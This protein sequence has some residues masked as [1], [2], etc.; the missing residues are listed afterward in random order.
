[1]LNIPSDGICASGNNLSTALPTAVMELLDVSGDVN[2]PNEEDMTTMSARD[3]PLRLSHES[4]HLTSNW[5]QASIHSCSKPRVKDVSRLSS[6]IRRSRTSKDKVEGSTNGCSE[7]HL[8]SYA[9]T[10][11][12]ITILF[13]DSDEDVSVCECESNTVAESKTDSI[14]EVVIIH[15]ASSL[16]EMS[17][18]DFK[19]NEEDLRRLDSPSA[20][21]K[22]EGSIM[23]P[24]MTGKVC[25]IM[26]YTV[27]LSISFC[28]HPCFSS[29]S[30]MKIA[31]K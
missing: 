2:M 11:S 5:S 12:S 18:T 7:D 26:S 8:S 3:I 31:L 19:T 1:M 25:N 23:S 15:K 4:I 29:P 14:P 28:S 20:A 6:L 13:E 22:F 24:K 10:E 9:H 16:E 21:N 17:D 27:P 30:E